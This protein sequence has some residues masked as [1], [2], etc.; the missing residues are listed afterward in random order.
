MSYEQF[1][2]YMARYKRTGL[3]EPA[4]GPEAREWPR[5]RGSSRRRDWNKR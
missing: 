2:E 5:S 1:K 3:A 4:R